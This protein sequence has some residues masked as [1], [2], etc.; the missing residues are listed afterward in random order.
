MLDT[1]INAS[2]RKKLLLRFWSS[3]RGF[4]NIRQGDRHALWMSTGLLILVLAQLG[5]NYGINIWNRSLFDAV[6]GKD[7]A[8]VVHLTLIFIPLVCG[9]LLFG[10]AQVAT[11]M[12]LQRRWRAWLTARVTPGGWPIIATINSILRAAATRIPSI[13]WRMIFGLQRMRPLI[14]SPALSQHFFPR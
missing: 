7:Q 6:E 10:V 3:A 4:W 2:H 13:V 14:L 1:E 8:S 9:A 12:S 5:F 11:R